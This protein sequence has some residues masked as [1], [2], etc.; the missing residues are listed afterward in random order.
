MPVDVDQ[1]TRPITHPQR[2]KQ[3]SVDIELFPP[4]HR[5]IRP[6]ADLGRHRERRMQ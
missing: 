1:G 3:G 4:E 6:E 2:V 5:A